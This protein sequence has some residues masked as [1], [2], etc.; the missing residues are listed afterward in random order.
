MLLTLAMRSSR[1]FGIRL[2]L[3]FLLAKS[4][5]SPS[6]LAGRLLVFRVPEHVTSSSL[7]S[8]VSSLTGVPAHLFYLTVDGKYFSHGSETMVRLFPG[9]TVRMH[10]RL[11]GGAAPAGG[12]ETE[13]FCVNCNRGGCWPTKQRCFRC[14]FPR[15]ESDRMRGAPSSAPKGG[16]GKGQQQQQRETQFLGRAPLP[17]RNSLR[18]RRGDLPRKRSSPR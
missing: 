4:R 6:V 5:C 11:K 7:V 3:S 1:L 8:T 13:W 17:G 12:F 2:S 9:Q 15:A 18:H 16:K 14:N 10:G